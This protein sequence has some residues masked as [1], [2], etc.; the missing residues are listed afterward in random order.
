MKRCLANLVLALVAS[1][2]AVCAFAQSVSVSPATPLAGQ[3][4]VLTFTQPFNCTA[5][6]PVLSATSM[7]SITFDSVLPNGIVNCPAIP[8][9]PPENSVFTADISAPIVAGSYTVIWNIYLAQSSGAPVLQSSASAALVVAAGAQGT[10][11]AGYTGNWY[12]PGESGHGFSIEVLPDNTMLAEW[13][14]FSPDG[15]HM[16]I[17]ATGP[18]D[19][20][21]A[22]LSAFSPSGAGG[23]FPPNFNASTL[24]NQPWGTIT[25]TF[26][27]C[28]HGQVTWHSTVAGYG[29]GTIPITRLTMPA[30]LSCQ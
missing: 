15:S 29:D 26:S 7:N 4:V 11:T 17:V 12:D 1:S 22:Q 23:L 8:F 14:V 30:G 9:P 6:Q 2:M 10:I 27:D 16:W 19:G 20:S 28:N 5:P 21:T 24:H 25:F 13:Y 3:A 18:I